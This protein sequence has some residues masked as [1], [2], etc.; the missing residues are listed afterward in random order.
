MGLFGW[1]LGVFS[2]LL[3]IFLTLKGKNGQPLPK[4][5]WL[6]LAAGLAGLGLVLQLVGAAL[7][8]D[9]AAA[10]RFAI[11]LALLATLVFVVVRR[12]RSD[13]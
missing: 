12:R 10:M 3:L 9:P 7:D 1:A 11:L 13:A 5:R 4:S 2:L 6:A 8:R